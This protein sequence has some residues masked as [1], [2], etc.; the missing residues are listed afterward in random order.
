MNYEDF[1][2]KEINT[3]VVKHLPIA[4]VVG[5]NFEHESAIMV[6]T[7]EEMYKF[8]PCNDPKDAWPLICESGMSIEMPHPDL[9]MTGTSTIYNPKGDD[10]IVDFDST[11]KSLRAATGCLLKMKDDKYGN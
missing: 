1:T 6:H 10:W 2:D 4:F 7:I 9:G 11:D 5:S 3:M 8:D